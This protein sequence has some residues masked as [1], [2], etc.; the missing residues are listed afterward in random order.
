MRNREEM[1]DP[2]EEQLMNESSPLCNE[3]EL[4]RNKTH[5]ESMDLES[6]LESYGKDLDCAPME[7][8]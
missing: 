8:R 7:R 5:D 6:M 1:S 3:I 2:L 4:R